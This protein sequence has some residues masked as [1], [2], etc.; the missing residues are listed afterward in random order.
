MQPKHDPLHGEDDQLWVGWKWFEF[1]SK[2]R[3]EAFKFFL[4]IFGALITVA[5]G[6]VQTQ[7]IFVATVSS[8][9]ALWA[10]LIFW[11]I[12]R[13]SLQL[14]EIGEG[15]LHARWQQLAF[16]VDLNPVSRSSVVHSDG[17]RF[18]HAFL[19][20]FLAA[21]LSA[22]AMLGFSIYLMNY[23]QQIFVPKLH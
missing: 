20:V 11:Q 15:V 17:L 4:T 16:N 19:L 6:F 10:A 18:K 3:L 14:I 23:P 22:F 13:R 5:S 12:D 7:Y 9:L 21:G 8:F 2:Q 1:H